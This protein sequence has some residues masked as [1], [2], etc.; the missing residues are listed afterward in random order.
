MFVT[1]IQTYIQ[2]LWLPESLDLL[3]RETKKQN[4]N[5]Q[6]WI[7]FLIYLRAKLSRSPKSWRKHSG[8]LGND[9]SSFFKVGGLRIPIISFLMLVLSLWLDF[10]STLSVVS[11]AV[12]QSE[13]GASLKIFWFF[14][15]RSRS[16]YQCK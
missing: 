4:V 3:D 15:I 14:N 7:K 16:N 6:I 5:A 8:K 11:W 10:M 2:T 12:S 9:F 1:Y 13:F